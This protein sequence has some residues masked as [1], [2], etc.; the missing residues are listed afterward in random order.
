MPF[1]QF[2]TAE[3]Q[4]D[5]R[6][7]LGDVGSGTF[8]QHPVTWKKRVAAAGA[9][10]E[11]PAITETLIELRGLL[12]QPEA[13]ENVTDDRARE[14]YD[15]RIMFMRDY[16]AEQGQLD[17]INLAGYAREWQ[18]TVDTLV[19]DVI[20]IKNDGQLVEDTLICFVDLRRAD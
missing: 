3:D 13:K 12:L 4:A 11:S 2:L 7:A 19:Y 9:F 6:Q 1:E 15:L 14:D 5:I 10:G 8:G 18:F 16:L 20:A 17:L